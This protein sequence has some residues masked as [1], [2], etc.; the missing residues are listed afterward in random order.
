MDTRRN[1]AVVAGLAGAVALA[2]PVPA[3]ALSLLDLTESVFTSPQASFVMGAVGGALVMGAVCGTVSLVRGRRRRARRGELDHA[4]YAE[5]ALDEAVAEAAPEAASM[6]APAAG[7]DPEPND[8]RP[9]RPRHFAEGVSFDDVEDDEASAAPA[10]DHATHDY[11]QIAENYVRRATFRERMA[12]RAQGVAA[13]LTA[14]MEASMMDGVPVLT[15]ADGSVGDVGTSWWEATVGPSVSHASGFAPED[16][17]LAIPSD[18][19]AVTDLD[20]LANAAARTAGVPAPAPAPAPVASAAAARI[21]SRVAHVDE[22]AF[23]ERSAE[24]AAEPEDEW[25]QAL[26]SLDERLVD[27]GP[28]QDPIEFIDAAGGADTLDE[29]DN[30]EPATAFIPFKTPAGHPEVV[31]T[32]SYVDYLIGEE[33]S[34]NQSGSARTS[35]RRF[36]R[37]LEGGTSTSRRL[38]DSG[39][40]R[41]ASAPEPVRAAKHFSTPVAAEA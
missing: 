30:L 24:E 5:P 4:E 35:S 29:P 23:P 22:A 21:S 10:A 39:S 17:A 36:L 1:P 38:G 32:D 13:T 33:F 18:F 16:E 31:D 2:V 14:R 40:A 12:R 26:R 7:T 34:K 25:A 3:Q 41:R 37:V 27:E 28:A 6:A 20:L 11:E 8:P 15:R 9:H 19:T